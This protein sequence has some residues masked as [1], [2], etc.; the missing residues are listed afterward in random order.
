MTRGGELTANVSFRD[1]WR[2]ARIQ[3]RAEVRELA[4]S[5]NKASWWARIPVVRAIVQYPR[6]GAILAGA[7]HTHPRFNA[8][9]TAVFATMPLRSAGGKRTA[10]ATVRSLLAGGALYF[11]PV[12]AWGGALLGALTLSPTAGTGRAVLA[13]LDASLFIGAACVGGAARLL[14]TG[15]VQSVNQRKL[16]KQ[17]VRAVT[18]ARRLGTP[19]LYAGSFASVERGAGV[20]HALES[21]SPDSDLGLTTT[22]LVAHTGSARLRDSYVNDFG[23]TDLGHATTAG[24]SSWLLV[25]YGSPPP[26]AKAAVPRTPIGPGLEQ[27]L[28][29]RATEISPGQRRPTNH[30]QGLGG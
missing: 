2:A 14:Y 15:A 9:R 7:F 11:A 22:T 29:D 3:S 4:R 1:A 26:R 16:R 8:S 18:E 12:L 5:G 10:R 23:F 13:L 17:E 19:V 6:L 30:E 24:R 21:L 20:R 28:L 27:Q 25:R